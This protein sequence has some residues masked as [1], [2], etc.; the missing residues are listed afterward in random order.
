[1]SCPYYTKKSDLSSLL[2]DPHEGFHEARLGN[3]AMNDIF[4]TLAIAGVSSYATNT[5]YWQNLLAWFAIAEASH[6]AFGVRTQ[7]LVDLGV[8]H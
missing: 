2:G 7:L 5:P 3:Y 6:V 4:G 1:M 8:S